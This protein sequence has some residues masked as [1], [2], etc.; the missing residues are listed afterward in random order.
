[1]N[2]SFEV[3]LLLQ[4]DPKLLKY[5]FYA[6]LVVDQN[7]TG[8][9]W[10]TSFY[11]VPNN[12][13]A[14]YLQVTAAHRDIIV[15]LAILPLAHVLQDTSSQATELRMWHGVYCVLEEN[16]AMLLVCLLRMEIVMQVGKIT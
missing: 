16:T 8:S 6:G 4:Y 2:S 9:F 13:Q 1:M 7:F 3:S 12:I 15:K 11:N 10:T 14:V 5:L